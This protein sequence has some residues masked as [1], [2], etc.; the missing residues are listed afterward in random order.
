VAGRKRTYLVPDGDSARGLVEAFAGFGFPL[1]MAC[2]YR[3]NRYSKD[4]DA[5]AGDWDVT[6]FDTEPDAV[7]GRSEWEGH[8]R[9]GSQEHW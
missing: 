6:V 7:D 1:V 8:A 2:P 3:P 5:G 4:P 9:A